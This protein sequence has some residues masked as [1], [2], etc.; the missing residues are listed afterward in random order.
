MSSCRGL[1]IG[2]TIGC[3]SSPEPPRLACP[4]C[5]AETP[6]LYRVSYS[7]A[8]RRRVAAW[9]CSWCGQINPEQATRPG[10]SNRT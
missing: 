3:V 8:Q 1:G 4:T 6:H 10:P 5:K 9:T 7:D 2:R